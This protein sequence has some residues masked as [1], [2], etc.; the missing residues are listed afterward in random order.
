MVCITVRKNLNLSKLLS[1]KP[2]RVENLLTKKIGDE[3][4]VG[5]VIAKKTG[6]FSNLKLKSPISGILEKL[7]LAT[8]M[9]TIK[10]SKA[11]PILKATAAGE[12]KEIREN[13]GD[14]KIIIET[15]GVEIE[16]KM[17]VG[18]K[19]GGQLLVL[20]TDKVDLPDLTADLTEKI[21]AAR[22]WGLGS[23]SKAEALGVTAVL[24]EEFAD[25]DFLS[26]DGEENLSSLGLKKRD[27][28]LL[29][30]SS[31]NFEKVLKYAGCQV[32]AWGKEKRL[33]IAN[34]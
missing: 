5:E 16:A 22:S 3:V 4:K 10:T 27:F 2:E 34:S 14:K 8:G 20:K 12:E 30:F 6:L 13:H 28:T 18:P 15:E 1:V 33:L 19:T 17:G 29:V 25:E 31:E 24:G 26:V 9:L 21:L 23:V 11:E 7:D 32:V